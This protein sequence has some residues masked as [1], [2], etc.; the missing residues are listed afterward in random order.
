MNLLK[1]QS[2]VSKA[3]KSKSLKKN[4]MNMNM[5]LRQPMTSRC[6]AVKMKCDINAGAGF[7]PTF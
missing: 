4:N 1:N 6:A 2:G 7:I 3:K 5:N